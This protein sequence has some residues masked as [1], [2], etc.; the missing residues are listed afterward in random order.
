MQ[1][2]ES[3][4]ECNASMSLAEVCGGKAPWTMPAEYRK[5]FRCQAHTC[6]MWQGEKVEGVAEFHQ[7][8]PQPLSANNS[9]CGNAMQRIV[10]KSHQYVCINHPLGYIYAARVQICDVANESVDQH[11]MS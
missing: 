7:L 1:F 6:I 5:G 4:I 2:F 8:N 9:T 3:S 10:G 11:L